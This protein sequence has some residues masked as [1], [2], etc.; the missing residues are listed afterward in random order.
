MQFSHLAKF[1]CSTLKACGHMFG[2][3]KNLE[4]LVPQ[5]RKLQGHVC[6]QKHSSIDGLPWSSGPNNMD[7]GIGFQKLGT[8]GGP[9][10]WVRKCGWSP[11]KY[12]LPAVSLLYLI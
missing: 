2:V 5:P 11:K 10:P 1:G 8:F 12:A 9:T 6:S 3:S 7:I 4:A